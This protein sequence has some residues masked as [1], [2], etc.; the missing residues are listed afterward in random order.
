MHLH[1]YIT[2]REREKVV[3]LHTAR[4]LGYTGEHDIFLCMCARV[5]YWCHVKLTTMVLSSEFDRQL[6]R[7]ELSNE[8]WVMSVEVML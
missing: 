4:E 1:V 7:A 6:Y 5:A 8:N 2:A 3:L